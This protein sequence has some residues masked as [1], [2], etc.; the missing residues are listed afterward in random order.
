VL[1]IY[2]ARSL[3]RFAAQEVA[4]SIRIYIYHLLSN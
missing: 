4:D 2:I 3:Y 1:H